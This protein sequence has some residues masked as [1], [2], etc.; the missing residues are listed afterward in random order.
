MQ[1]DLKFDVEDY[2]FHLQNV[3]GK[4]GQRRFLIRGEPVS[5]RVA[6][7]LG[8]GGFTAEVDEATW[9]PLVIDFNDTKGKPLKTIKVAGLHQVDGIW[10]PAVIE[11]QHHGT[12]HHTRFS[13]SNITHRQSLPPTLFNAAALTRGL[14]KAW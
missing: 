3:T 14:P 4:E 12:G 7:E 10:T 8:Y 5:Q 9:F 1:S 6:K 11:A 13:Y 2:H